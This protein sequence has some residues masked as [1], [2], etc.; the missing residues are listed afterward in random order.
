MTTLKINSSVVKLVNKNNEKEEIKRGIEIIKNLERK[1]VASIQEELD[2]TNNINIE[3][4]DTSNQNNP[5]LKTYNYQVK[6]E[7]SLILGDSRAASIYEYNILDQSYFIAYKGRNILTAKSNGEI[8]KAINLAPKNIFLTYGLNDVEN[9]DNTEEFIQKYSEII[10]EIKR[11]TPHTKIYVNS[12][13]EVSIKGLQSIPRYAL[14][15]KYNESLKKMCSDLDV[16][17]IDMSPLFNEN[18]FDAD[19]VHFKPELNKRW[20]NLLIEEANL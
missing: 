18:D 10:N 12:I 1:D 15:P 13:L 8:E 16:N 5:F 4:D 7:N 9:F 19:G 17:Y 3:E 11:R 2:N 14:I 20:L 6:F